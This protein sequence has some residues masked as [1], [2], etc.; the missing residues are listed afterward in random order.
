[1]YF[2]LWQP[3]LTLFTIFKI[4]AASIGSYVMCLTPC[5]Y[6]LHCQSSIKGMCCLCLCN[7]SQWG[8]NCCKL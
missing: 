7:T 2:H 1:M 6:Y 4:T 3:S 5:L 8:F